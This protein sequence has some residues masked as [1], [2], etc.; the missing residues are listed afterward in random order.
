MFV[1]K[2]HK[3]KHGKNFHQ[4][5]ESSP[6]EN[7][8]R[9]K[10]LYT[11]FLTSQSTEINTP[12]KDSI[13]QDEIEKAFGPQPSLRNIRAKEN[14][15]DEQD[16]SGKGD[17]ES[18]RAAHNETKEMFENTIH[19]LHVRR[20]GDASVRVASGTTLTV[21]IDALLSPP[22]ALRMGRR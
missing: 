16:S 18:R 13:S 12:Y 21:E 6:S 10:A 20:R 22:R 2:V 14:A 19:H 4:H 5:L 1:H 11:A 8:N 3:Q 7:S 17:I 15:K 9:L